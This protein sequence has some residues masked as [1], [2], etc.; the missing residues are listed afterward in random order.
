MQVSLP[1][2][3]HL[4]GPI[5]GAGPEPRDH[6][7]FEANDIFTIES[8]HQRAQ[9]SVVFQAILRDIFKHADWSELHAFFTKRYDLGEVPSN[10]TIRKLVPPQ[11]HPLYGKKQFTV[12]FRADLS[13][14]GLPAD[15][16]QLLRIGRQMT[17]SP[18]G[19]E[20]IFTAIGPGIGM[21]VGA[22][23]YM[24]LVYCGLP[25]GS[26]PAGSS[27]QLDTVYGWE[28]NTAEDGRPK[29][30][31]RGRTWA[32]WS[33]L[34][35]AITDWVSAH[36][37]VWVGMGVLGD[38]EYELRPGSQ[39]LSTGAVD[40]A[41]ALQSAFT[42][43]AQR[44]LDFHGIEWGFLELEIH[45]EL[46]N[47]FYARFGKKPTADYFN[48]LVE[49]TSWYQPDSSLVEERALKACPGTFR[50]TDWE[51]WLLSMEGGDVVVAQTLFQ[52]SIEPTGTH[53]ALAAKTTC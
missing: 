7:G 4:R 46:M 3:L 17:Y 47:S 5:P 14:V 28:D 30:P 23:T 29:F 26:A 20:I 52:V 10:D 21:A 1:L 43:L 25:P 18:S 31:G 37:S 2:A 34:W 49:K 44:P 12:N 6:K 36:D 13:S 40:A 50:G 39:S 16:P 22:G 35:R 9:A 8:T 11:N 53:V 51:R 32:E 45:V 24:D 27:H 42:Q 33:R 41:E 48:K 19:P 15:L 38:G